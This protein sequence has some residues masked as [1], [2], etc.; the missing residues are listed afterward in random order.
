M[1]RESRMA[2]LALALMGTAGVVASAL[3]GEQTLTIA[4]TAY[5]AEFSSEN[6]ALVRFAV[7]GKAGSI[8]HSGEQGLWQIVG[9]GA[10]R[11]DA[12]EF[13]PGSPERSFRYDWDAGTR[14]LRLQYRS[15]EVDV[16]VTA[17]GTD[18]H[19]DLQAQVQPHSAT[20]L[21]FSLPARLRFDPAQLV[22][23]VCPA[24]GNQSVGT[25]FRGRF[26]QAQDEEQPS[27]WT[28]QTAGPKGYQLLYG[29]PL[30]Y[31]TDFDPP[32]ALRVTEPGQ[33]WLG[34]G[35]A[36]RLASTKA[37][38]NRPPKPDQADL[39]VIDSPH[40][41]YFSACHLGGQGSL[42][43]IGGAVRDEEAPLSLDVVSATIGH[44]AA[45]AGAERTKVG[46]VAV[47]HGP[48]SGNWSDVP[49]ADWRRRLAQA[50]GQAGGGVQF[51]ELT[52]ASQMLQAAAA[53]DYLAILN[54]YGE[55]LPCRA[56]DALETVVAAIGRYVRAGG[57]WFEV[58]GHPFHSRLVPVR[59]YQ[60]RATY[61]PAFADFF[62]A[63]S[64]AGQAAV[65]RVQPRT[66]EP[67]EGATNPQAIFVPGRLG[68]GGDE[69][70]GWC[71]RPFAVYLTPGAG[72]QSPV[73]RL[74]AGQGA[75]DDLRAYCRAND[76]TR[77]LADKLP[78]DVLA[79]FQN[80]VLVYY[81]GTCA[82]KLA[83]LAQLPVP[84]QIH[85]ADYLHG[86]FDKQYPDHL[87]PHPDFGT[88]DQ[89][90]RF[91]AEAQ[92]LGH[93][94]IPYTNPTWWCDGPKGP[95]FAQHGD[96]PLLKGLDGQPAH[97]RY[98][99]NEG[100]TVCHWHPAVRAAN[101]KTVAQFTE[102]Y[103]CDVL[104]QDQCGARG[105]RY[106]TNPASPA[107]WAYT[108]GLLSMVA[109]DCRRRPLSTE[110]GWDGVV[111]AESQ[112]CGM[113]WSLV[114][115]E[116]APAWRQLLKTRYAPATWEIFPVAQYIAHDK[117]ALLHHDL[118]QFVT[119]RET[120]AWTLGLG[121][122]LSYRTAAAGLAEEAP[123][124]WLRW[125]DRLQ[126]SVCARYVG[127]PL[128]DFSHERDAAS[129]EDD[130]GLLRAR[131]DTLQVIANLSPRPRAVPDARLAP[132]GFAATA[133]GLVAANL[134]TLGGTDFGEDGVSFVTQ[135][136]A[137]RTAVW[138][139]ARPGA[140]VAVLAPAALPD[141]ATLAGDGHTPLP[142]RGS[143][144]VWHFTVPRR[145][146]ATPA[147]PPPALAAKAP[148][149]WPQKPVVAVLD[150]EGLTPVWTRIT[151]S[152]WL[153]ALNES[154][155][156]S[157]WGLTV[158]RIT[159]AAELADVLQAGPTACW[160]IVNPY[161]ERF[162]VSGPGQW[163]AMLDLVRRYVN[164]GGCWWETAGYSFYQA[165]WRQGEQWQ[166]EP[167]GPQGLADLRVPLDGGDVDQPAEP[168]AVTPEGRAWL[169]QDLV[170][171][172]ARS[173]SPVNRGLPRGPSDRGH[174]ALVAGRET[175]W[176][177]GYR[178]DGW[179]WLWRIGGFWPN[180][181]VAV[182]VTVATLEYLAS[183]PPQPVTPGGRKYLWAGTLTAPGAGRP[184]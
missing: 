126:K 45:T 21:E 89:F 95:T 73:V 131:Y 39:V 119:N 136:D 84:C 134:Q 75:A 109:A 161:G 97:E 142:A 174:V 137:T 64:Q 52:T 162:P 11:I 53:Q 152:D 94:V 26:F 116:H 49:V 129:A 2:A 22:R 169:D 176:L 10:Q 78:A 23:F 171:R 121:F 130:D 156:A 63:E 17:T 65:Y 182:P 37:T 43:R 172:L 111:N 184:Q 61:P 117:T 31:R 3:A 15:A 46:L 98:A 41:P 118:G 157:A 143:G 55:G 103:P 42:W 108:E 159:T 105:W 57:H 107:A 16:A 80:A 30:V 27:S 48:A 138:V 150:L 86:G 99:H 115:T 141:A 62:H 38:V 1:C 178:L 25:A 106:D 6:G 7:R 179:G 33:A 154:R 132:W 51:V 101:E 4:G 164:Q 18:E 163:R 29:G 123:R 28:A 19:L 127:Q 140:E 40:G 148:R 83:H 125:L 173:A 146:G 112:L 151:A 77:R 167:V 144:R 91:F 36:A 113:T 165:V 155:L 47:T 60:Y 96:G 181:E 82:D 90:R 160:A 158:R 59:F 93:L 128:S 87:P 12:A 85:F 122:S 50:V 44:L 76:I 70:G 139:Y 81:A 14:R 180:P 124:E 92:R 68:C 177:G 58:G 149:D 104:F 79:R 9:A 145:P 69:T 34:A 135:G 8:W 54:P 170:T 183:H 166:S 120:L 88:P 102:D 72:W 56:G 175:D 32:V 13:S 20:V 110:S 71:E 5:T 100:F 147:A 66:W 74:V 168:L 35:L 133:P 67:W 24:D 114:P 153:R